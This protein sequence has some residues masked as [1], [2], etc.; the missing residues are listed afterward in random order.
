MKTKLRD[1]HLFIL[2]FPQ[3][4]LIIAH[5]DETVGRNQKIHC[6]AHGHKKRLNKIT[7]IQGLVKLRD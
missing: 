6:Q 7:R 5:S 1:L 4:M 2:S 3:G